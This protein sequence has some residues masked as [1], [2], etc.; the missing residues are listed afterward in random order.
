MITAPIS[1]DEYESFR[2]FLED[3]SGIVLGDNKHYLITSRITRLMAE[4]SIPSFSDLLA[5]AQEDSRLRQRIMDAMTTNETSWFRDSYPYEFLTEK[6]YPERVRQSGKDPIRIWS[7]ACSTGQ[8]PYSVGITTREFL[9]K[10]PGLMSAD[11]IQIWGTDISSKALQ[12]ARAGLYDDV[13]L[14]RGMSAELRKRYFRQEDNQWRVSDDIKKRVNFQE[15]NL[16][17]GFASLGKFDIIFCRNVLIY[18]SP[19]L[20]ADIM[21][22]MAQALKPNGYLILGGSETISGYSEDFDIMRW[23]SVGVVYQLKPGKKK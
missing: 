20:K 23:K 19:D 12:H 16:K 7:A 3:A 2:E 14:S 8:E 6:F 21:Y 11:N 13:A 10:N 4:L 17:T 15:L 9:L 18:F 22:R 1:P 5:R